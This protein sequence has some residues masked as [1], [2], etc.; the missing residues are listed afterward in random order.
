[1]AIP[2]ATIKKRRMK[3]PGFREGYD[4]LAEEYALADTLIDARTR[5]RSTSI[6]SKSESTRRSVHD[7]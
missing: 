6:T 2:I 3:E 1:V 4:A 5:V 7:R